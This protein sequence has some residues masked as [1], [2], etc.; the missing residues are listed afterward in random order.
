MGLGGRTS[1]RAV[2]ENPPGVVTGEYGDRQCGDERL[3]ASAELW[4][5]THAEKYERYFVEHETQFRAR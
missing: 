4:R 2:Q 3:W 1:G 5:T